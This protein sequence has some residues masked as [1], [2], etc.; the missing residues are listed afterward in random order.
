MTAGPALDRDEIAGYNCSYVAIDHPRAFD[1]IM[2]ILMCGTG[3]GFSVEEKYVQQLPVIAEEHHKSDTVIR[4]SDSRIG[5][6]SAY[7]ELLSLLYS[8]KVPIW[9]TSNVR[10]AGARLKIFGGRA[11]GPEPYNALCQFTVETFKKAA[12]RRLTTVECHDLVCKIA[13]VVIV[14]GVR[15]SALI[16]LSDLRDRPMAKS[17]SGQWWTDTPHRALANNSA[18][19]NGRP[20]FE[21]FLR[22]WQ[23]LHES[24]S[25]ER[26]IFNRMAATKQ[27]ASSG[28]RDT[29][30][31]EYGTN[32]C[33]EIILR[34]M[35]LCN[36]SEV[37]IRPDD[38]FE[39]LRSKVEI[40]TILGTFQSTLT[41]FRYVR[42]G[43][44]KNQEEE[45]LLGVSLTGIFDNHFTYNAGGW[46]GDRLRELKEHAITTNIEWAAKLGISVSGAITCVKPSGTVSQ[47]ASC[48]SGIHPAFSS[49]YLR[50][51]RG[52]NKDPVTKFLRDV[53]VP[54]EPEIN[55][56]DDVTVFYF[57]IAAPAGAVTR[58][59]LT[60]KEHLNI[61]D[62][63]RSNWCE[64]NPSITVYFSDDEFLGV[65]SWVWSTFDRVGGVS[66]LPR[67]DHVYA[68]APYQEL[69]EAEY[70]ERKRTF[71]DIDW[72]KFYEY[73]K[74]D[75]TI[76]QHDL[77]C[78][79][80]LCEL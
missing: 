72:E 44:R 10:P 41:N 50:S 6:A 73:E 36:L 78:S 77:A 68:Q 79:A 59:K 7:R 22:E 80:G 8:G 69:T 12:G 37:I 76:N 74:E 75:Q 55:H 49:Y 53:G 14:G 29:A 52:D 1:E 11:S 5:W 3:V 39:T 67:S 4:V 32:P 15:R 71:P 35:G 66:F 57:P 40:A 46:T 21:T 9:D 33:G 56:P 54:H 28:R 38:S 20:D 60:A 2:Y 31:W 63:Y 19:Y 70:L 13:D 23:L 64:H 25:G 17:K 16:S 24:R 47:L 18:V 45:R 34:S 58:D 62:N 65:G 26:G 43:W 30:G 51:V 27:A 42:K 61:Y 48:S